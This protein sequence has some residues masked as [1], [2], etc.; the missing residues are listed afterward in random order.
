MRMFS[1]M[2][3]NDEITGI[4]STTPRFLQIAPFQCAHGNQL[5]A[6]TY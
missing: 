1:T 6:D 5:P 2:V 4:Y 3:R